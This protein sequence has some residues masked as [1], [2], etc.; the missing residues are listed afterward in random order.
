[1]LS[2]IPRVRQDNPRLRRRWFHDEY[3]DLFVWQAA[4]GRI[5]GFQLCYDVGGDERVLSWSE[6]EGFTLDT[7]D[8]GEESPRRNMSPILVAD[9][10]PPAR[11]VIPNFVAHSA[12]VELVIRG[13]VLRKLRE[14]VR[15][16]PRGFPRRRNR[17]SR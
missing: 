8:S 17:R 12:R 6:A 11:S 2:E 10:R 7:V 5:A 14:C 9:D 4:H 1:M 3:F 15:T 16:A 13:F